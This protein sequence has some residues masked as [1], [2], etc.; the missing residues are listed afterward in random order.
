MRTVTMHEAKTNLSRLVADLK[1]GAETEII[2]AVG[3]TPA[4]R[5]L[6][7]N[8]CHD[9]PIGYDEGRFV[10]PDDFDAPDPDII[11]MF[12]GNS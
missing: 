7:L 6:P 2:I 5:L 11:E 4:A 3:K 9:R 10:V 12:E 1:S 8:A